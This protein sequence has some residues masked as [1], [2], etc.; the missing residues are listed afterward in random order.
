MH[1]YVATQSCICT[2]AMQHCLSAPPFACL[3]C[4]SFKGRPP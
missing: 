4:T 2:A 3:P 1:A